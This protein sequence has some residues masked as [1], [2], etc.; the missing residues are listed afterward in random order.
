LCD[1][2]AEEFIMECPQNGTLGDAQWLCEEGFA[3]YSPR[4]CESEWGALI[5][6]ATE[7]T[8]ECVT[9]TVAGCDAVLDALM[10]CAS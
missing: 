4:G 10:E 9:G 7:G 5:V 3:Q 1:A 2:Y 6:C 8:Y